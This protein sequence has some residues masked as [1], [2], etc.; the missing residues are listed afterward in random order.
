M[1][2]KYFDLIKGSSFNF[3]AHGWWGKEKKIAAAKNSIR[4]REKTR[5]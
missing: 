2:P 3:S 4:F 5:H 1:L